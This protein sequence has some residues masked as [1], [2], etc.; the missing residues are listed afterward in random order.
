MTKECDEYATW[1]LLKTY[2]SRRG[3]PLDWDFDL[4]QKKKELRQSKLKTGVEFVKTK[5]ESTIKHDSAIKGQKDPFSDTVQSKT[6]FRA[7]SRDKY[8]VPQPFHITDERKKSKMKSKELS[9]EEKE[10]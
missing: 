1:D 10:L 9:T 5:L 3:R 2:F 7:S 8:T 4:I 6:A